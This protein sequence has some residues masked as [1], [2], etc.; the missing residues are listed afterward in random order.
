MKGKILILNLAFLLYYYSGGYMK[1]L[2]IKEPFASLIMMGVKHIETRSFKTNYRGE[3][4]IHAS[5]GTHK[6]TSESRI[7][8][9][10][11]MN[12]LNN[13][14][15]ISKCNIVDCIC[16]DEEFIENVK[17]NNPDEYICGDYSVGRYAWIL[18]DVEVLKKR[19]PAKGK[20]GIWNL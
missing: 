15:I 6:I 17:K 13:G 2:S 7:L 10:I 3:L 14:F 4:Y 1:V 11:D 5:L 9:L 20:L 8:N 16:M 19:I 18:S 12:N